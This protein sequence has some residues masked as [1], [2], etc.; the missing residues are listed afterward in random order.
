[1]RAH[2]YIIWFVGSGVWWLV[3]ALAIHHGERQRALG[4]LAIAI[5]FFCS[6]MFFQRNAPRL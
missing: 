3:A 4:S 1:M 6:G 5:V 2:S